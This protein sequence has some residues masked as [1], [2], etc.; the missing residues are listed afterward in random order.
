MEASM[1]KSTRAGRGARRRRARESTATSTAGRART[2]VASAAS[3]PRYLASDVNNAA[4][5][6]PRR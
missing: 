3:G 4:W 2:D 1:K 5:A 6:G